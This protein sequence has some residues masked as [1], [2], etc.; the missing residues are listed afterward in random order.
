MTTSGEASDTV[1]A[2]SKALSLPTIS[3]SFG[4][5][6]DIIPWRNLNIQQKSFLVQIQPPADVTPEIIRDIITKQNFTN[7]AVLYDQNFGNLRI[8]VEKSSLY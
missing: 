1:K 8:I 4:Q 6:D 7:A 5:K 2:F 3:T